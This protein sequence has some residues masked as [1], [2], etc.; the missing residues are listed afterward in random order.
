MKLLPLIYLF[1]FDGCYKIDCEDYAQ[2]ADLV[3]T[4]FKLDRNQIKRGEFIVYEVEIKNETR[5]GDCNLAYTSAPTTLRRIPR[6]K[7]NA[8]SARAYLDRIEP[9]IE[10]PAIEPNE[11]IVLRDSFPLEKE[12]QYEILLQIYSRPNETEKV[13]LE[14]RADNN[15]LELPVIT[16]IE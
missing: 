16:I 2:K 6:F 10:I 13:L 12:G 9:D 4:D 1:L 3:F 15:F 11:S 8:N 14:R 7:L 5:V